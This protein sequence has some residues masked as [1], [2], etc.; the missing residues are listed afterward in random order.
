MEDFFAEVVGFI[1]AMVLLCV[2]IMFFLGDKII[3]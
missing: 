1:F 3:F 2:V